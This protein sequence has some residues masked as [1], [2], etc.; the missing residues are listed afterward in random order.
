MKPRALITTAAGRTGSVAALELL[1]RGHPVRG[2]V[3]RDDHR[4]QALR[5]AGVEVIVGDLFDWRDLTRALDDVQLA[6]HCPPFDAQHLHGA[7][8]FALAAEQAGVE[9][10]ALMS[11]W[12]PHQLHPSVFQREH[13]LANNLYRRQAF[14][15]IHINPGMFAWTYFLGLPAIVRFG[16]LAL[17][18]GDGL[19]APPSNEDVGRVAAA[20]LA[21]AAHYVGRCLRPTGPTLITPSEAAESMSRALDRTIRYRAVSEK[22]FVKAAS[23]MHF[24]TF[25]IAQVRHY[26]KELRHGAFAG[27]TD[28]VEEVTGNVPDSFD[29]VAGRYLNDPTNITHDMTAGTR[30]AALRLGLRIATTRA[31]DLDKWE[32]T[33]DYPLISNAL[34]AH[35]NPEWNHEAGNGLLSLLATPDE[36]NVARRRLPELD[37]SAAAR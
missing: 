3:R 22:S 13:W 1:R 37:A 11:G 33:R 34:L 5:D 30:R 19:N 7:T 24:P 9:V 28:H 12:N 10:V 20:A 21:D 23:A 4:A 35:E 16:M 32:Q 14:D 2:L 26:A 36:Q 15:V 27:V 31:I 25:E 18:L 17:P 29:T 8:M 6:Y